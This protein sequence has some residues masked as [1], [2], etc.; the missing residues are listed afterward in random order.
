MMQVGLSYAPAN[1]HSL[2]LRQ[3]SHVTRSCGGQG[4]AREVAEHLLQLG[5]LNLDAAY[6]PLLAEWSRHAAQQ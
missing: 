6:Q 1:A 3:A 5:G 2:V 4:V